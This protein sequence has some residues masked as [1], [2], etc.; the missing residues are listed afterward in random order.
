M[1]DINDVIITTSHA[2]KS[3]SPELLKFVADSGWLLVERQHR[4]IP[5]LMKTYRVASVVVW[6][7]GRP[8]M[9]SASG[10][11]LFFHPSMA[12][13]RLS[14]FR[15]LGQTDMMMKAICLETGESFLDC[16]FGL[17]SDAIVASYFSQNG[18][19][20]GLESSP[21]L[22]YVVSWGMKSYQSR[23]SWL[24]EAIHRIRLINY[25]HQD[26]LPE[27]EDESFDVVYFDPMFREPLLKSVSMNPLRP[28]TNHN[29]LEPASIQQALRVARKRVVIKERI[30]SGELERLGCQQIMQN[31]NN[32]IAYGIL[33][34]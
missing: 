29:A 5:L 7:N 25:N 2:C 17:G 33:N 1:Q 11:Q 3:P 34:K 28:L 12:K 21:V 13:N 31:K 23:M 30:S 18:K 32:T 22:A 6:E 15:K 19:I 20:I 9:H 8:I 4:S 27:C 26:Y 24:D 14:F 16:T 10:E